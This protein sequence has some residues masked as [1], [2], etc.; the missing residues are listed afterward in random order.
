MPKGDF[1]P[2][3]IA[4]SLTVIAL[5]AVNYTLTAAV[6]QGADAFIRTLRL[7]EDQIHFRRIEMD[8]FYRIWLG[9][10]TDWN[11]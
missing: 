8:Y 1:S 2:A 7:A 4:A 11:A 5:S 10:E 3:P 6:A 9:S